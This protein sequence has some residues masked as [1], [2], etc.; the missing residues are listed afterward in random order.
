VAEASTDRAAVADPH[1]EPDRAPRWR[2]GIATL[3]VVV[4]GIGLTVLTVDEL[5]RDRDARRD[6]EPSVSG[7]ANK[8]SDLGPPPR[9]DEG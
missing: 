1:G 8:L 5:E 6:R 3:L 4:L 7:Q 2:P 9:R